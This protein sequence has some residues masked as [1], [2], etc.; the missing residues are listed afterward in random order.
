MNDTTPVIMAL[1]AIGV[2]GL[3]GGEIVDRSQIADVV[4]ALWLAGFPFIAALDYRARK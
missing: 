1:F 4:T 3:I 2:L